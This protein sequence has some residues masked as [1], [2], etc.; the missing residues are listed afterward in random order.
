M[1]GDAGDGGD[2]G[3]TGPREEA[4]RYGIRQILF[5]LDPLLA[6]FAGAAEV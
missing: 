1:N 4:I 3:D 6:A 5:V 2:P